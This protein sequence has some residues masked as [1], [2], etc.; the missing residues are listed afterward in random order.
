[1][2]IQWGLLLILILLCDVGVTVVYYLSVGPEF[3]A[4]TSDNSMHGLFPRKLHQIDQSH[5]VDE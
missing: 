4:S 3:V 5:I 1:M 2:D